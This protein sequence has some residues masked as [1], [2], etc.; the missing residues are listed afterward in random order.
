MLLAVQGNFFNG[1]LFG[2]LLHAGEI[3]VAEA[4][5]AI[6]FKRRNLFALRATLAVVLY[7]ALSVGGA[8]LFDRVFP[9]FRYLIAFLVSLALLPICFNV[10][11]WDE[12]Y[13]CCA[14]MAIQ[15][16]SFS[17]GIITVGVIGWDSAVITLP[18]SAV[19]TAIYLLTHLVCY[20]LCLRKM[21]DAHD[22][23]GAEHI[24]MV[25]LS[26]ILVTVVYI[27]QDNRQSLSSPDFFLWRTVFISYDILMLFMLFGMYDRGRLR[28]Q[29]AIL[30]Q[31][32]ESEARQYEMDKHAIE[33]VNIKCHDLKHQI[34]ALRGMAGE[35]Q[36]RALTD[37]ESA[38]MVYD[39]IAKTG[40]SAL[41]V[42]LT[43]KCLV[44]EQSG[45][46]LT[47]M[48]D[49]EKL[50]FMSAVDIYSLFGNAIDNAIRA[51]RK[52]EDAEKRIINISV[53]AR[54]KILGIH[55]ENYCEEEISFKDGLPVTTQSDTDK[56]G[57]G[58]L[59]MRRTAESYGGVM[60]VEYRNHLFY[61][62]FTLPIS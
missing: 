21:K 48:V 47:Y 14:A 4:I 19:Q 57:F 53:T 28:K 50:N 3:L 13:C 23:F 16:L 7:F 41:D 22:G 36:D 43:N 49:G 58:M 51:V 27:V 54:G 33:M 15:N 46:R 1:D 32:R 8:F 59:S 44:C 55:I 61:L 18:S 12:L 31:L 5:F 37:V 10:G 52:V 39:S 34:V 29:N 60:S 17:L 42:I 26:L 6:F 30:D 24:P 62:D 40:C 20:F 11:L 25:V 2:Y 35:E 9:Y 56:H 45:I 38:V